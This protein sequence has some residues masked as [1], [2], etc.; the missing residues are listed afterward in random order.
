MYKV[1]RIEY[2]TDKSISE[3]TEHEIFECDSYTP[4][5]GIYQLMGKLSRF[6]NKV[7]NYYIMRENDKTILSSY[8][9][10]ILNPADEW[11]PDV[12]I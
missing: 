11:H 6:C 9:K 10:A 7:V 12:S 1:I 4:A 5:L 3:A 8:S 2:D